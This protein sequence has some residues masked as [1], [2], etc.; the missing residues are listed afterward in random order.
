[1]MVEGESC[2]ENPS[3]YRR[4]G[5]CIFLW[6]TDSFAKHAFQIKHNYEISYPFEWGR[7]IFSTSRDIYVSEKFHLSR[8][9]IVFKS[10]RIISLEYLTK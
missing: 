3:G 6:N 9:R 1:M 7:I 8:V 4:L 2:D 5:Q 10:V